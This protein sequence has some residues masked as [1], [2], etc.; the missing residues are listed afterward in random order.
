MK[1]DNAPFVSKVKLILDSTD[2]A[3]IC[4][5]SIGDQLRPTDLSEIVYKPLKAISTITE[6]ISE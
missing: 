4:E 1:S 2:V 3:F 6:I 5:E